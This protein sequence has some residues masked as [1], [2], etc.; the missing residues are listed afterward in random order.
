MSFSSYGSATSNVH[1][2][3][4]YTLVMNW[5]YIIQE[6][7]CLNIWMKKQQIQLWISRLNTRPKIVLVPIVGST[8]KRW[9]FRYDSGE[10]K[11]RK[12]PNIRMML[13]HLHV[14]VNSTQWNPYLIA[15]PQKTRTCYQDTN[16][17]CHFGLQLGG[18]SAW[19]EPTNF[20][21][22]SS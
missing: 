8:L 20:K 22:S 13:C 21:G 14:D 4:K 12:V 17:L 9:W 1:F 5:G 15:N 6:I 18:L 11:H 7:T 19:C 16:Q 3:Q 10:K 2:P